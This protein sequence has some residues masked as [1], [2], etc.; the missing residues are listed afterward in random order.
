M[1]AGA[2]DAWRQPK[3]RATHGVAPTEESL[4]TSGGELIVQLS[5]GCVDISSAFESN[6]NRFSGATGQGFETHLRFAGRAVIERFS[7]WIEGGIE[8]DQIDIAMQIFD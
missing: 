2:A 4:L 5:A 8:R 3:K 6:G 1:R 7:E